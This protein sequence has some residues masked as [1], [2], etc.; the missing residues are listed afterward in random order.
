MISLKVTVSRNSTPQYFSQ[1]VWEE[2][3]VFQLELTNPIQLRK[4]FSQIVTLTGD[5]GSRNSED[6]V[7]QPV[8]FGTEALRHAPL[9][10]MTL[11]RRVFIVNDRRA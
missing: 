4:L 3:Y 6:T 5:L 2:K 9:K 1:F 8:F 10:S 11:R 7:Y